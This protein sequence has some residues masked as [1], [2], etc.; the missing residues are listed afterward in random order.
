[1]SKNFDLPSQ[2]KI[3]NLVCKLHHLFRYRDPLHYS[4]HRVEVKD[5]E[6]R[7]RPY[8]PISLNSDRGFF[9]L[10]VK[11]YI[12]G[13]VSTYLHSL[14]VGDYV[15]IRGPFEKLRYLPNMKERIGMIAGGTGITPMLQILREIC[16]PNSRDR[17]LVKLLFANH[18]EADIILKDTLQSLENSNPNISIKYILSEPSSPHWNGYTG[19][20]NQEILRSELPSPCPGTLIYVCGPPPMMD[21]ISGDKLP[22]KEQGPLRGL[23]KEIGY[24]GELLA[25]LHFFAHLI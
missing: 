8:T 13:A 10:A 7:I 20:L 17:T 19:R 23:L 24:D 11:S 2:L 6:G 22:N 4:T 18:A 12:D 14:N 15:E 9:D 5:H 21:T 25:Q 16:K 3:M 1:M